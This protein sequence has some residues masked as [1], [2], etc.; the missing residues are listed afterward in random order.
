M[1]KLSGPE[2]RDVILKVVQELEPKSNSYPPRP[3]L[4]QSDVLNELQKRLKTQYDREYELTVLV[5]W[6]DLFRTGYFGWGQ[7]LR[8]ATHGTFFHITDRGRRT[9][10]RLSRDPGN[11][12]GYLS[13]ARSV[14]R[15][16]AVTGSYLTE[17]VN[18]FIAD[19]HKSAAVMIG[20]AAESLCMAN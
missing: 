11:P 8:G 2:I 14:A 19:L 3:N 20:G 16:S 9:L 15:L 18:C 7:D 6:N 17:S 1:G 4:N 13:Y 12:Q 10:E 5:E